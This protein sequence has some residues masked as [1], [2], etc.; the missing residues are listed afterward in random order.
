MRG[1]CFCFLSPQSCRGPQVGQKDKE[2]T[3]CVCVWTVDPIPCPSWQ[4]EECHCRLSSPSDRSTVV[5]C[6]EKKELPNEDLHPRPLRTMTH[7]LTFRDNYRCDIWFLQPSHLSHSR[8]K[9]S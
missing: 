1:V 5:G 7:C 6:L 2:M 9:E 4:C 8:P 3:A